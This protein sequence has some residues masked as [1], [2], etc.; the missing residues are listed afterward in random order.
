[1]LR[2]L[3]SG[4]MDWTA[5]NYFERDFSKKESNY[6]KENKQKT[7][8]K[9]MVCLIFAT[10]RDVIL[11]KFVD[12]VKNLLRSESS[13]ILRR[14]KILRNLH[15]IFDYSTYSQKKGGDFVKLYGLLK[16]YELYIVLKI[17]LQLLFCGQR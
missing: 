5:A 4:K 9:F 10:I 8:S 6:F 3:L 11:S 14:P 7:C 13:Y 12:I 15:L 17:H 2:K 16:I 1:M